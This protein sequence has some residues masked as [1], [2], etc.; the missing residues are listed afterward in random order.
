M[1]LGCSL[2][3]LSTPF[4]LHINNFEVE[5]LRLLCNQEFAHAYENFDVHVSLDHSWPYIAK[6]LHPYYL[7]TILARYLQESCI[8]MFWGAPLG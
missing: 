2:L 6:K 3:V 4:H 7:F 8:T 1:P 5:L